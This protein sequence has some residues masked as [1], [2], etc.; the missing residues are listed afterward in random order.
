MKK[1]NYLLYLFLIVA[2]PL[3]S[4]C[5]DDDDDDAEPTTEDMLTAEEWRGDQVRAFGVDV[6]EDEDVVDLLFDFKT[7][8]LKFNSDGTY[9]AT[10]QDTDGANVTETGSWELS[11]DETQLTFD[12]VDEGTV[13]ID[14]LTDSE[15]RL[16]TEVE[17]PDLPTT[18]VELRFVR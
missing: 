5:D 8:R 6:T 18:E 7:M 14:L 2:L 17:L 16:T 10:Y 11:A 15:L 4:S 12:L 9:T 13:D 1:I 3:L